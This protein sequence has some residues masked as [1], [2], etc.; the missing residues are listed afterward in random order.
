MSTISTV[1]HALL[2]I[3]DTEGVHVYHSQC[4]RRHRPLTYHVASI[5]AAAQHEHPLSIGVYLKLQHKE[6]HCSRS[7]FMLNLTSRTS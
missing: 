6:L 7:V 1:L 4:V 5:R 2:V 3:A